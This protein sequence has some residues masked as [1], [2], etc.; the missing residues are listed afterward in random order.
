MFL[1][2]L[3]G[4]TFTGTPCT[5]TPFPS[6][7]SETSH[8]GLLPLNA[9]VKAR[10]PTTKSI[11]SHLTALTPSQPYYIY[12]R[13]TRTCTASRVPINA[14]AYAHTKNGASSGSPH[15]AL[16][17]LV[18]FCF[19]S[20][21]QCTHR[22]HCTR[23]C[24]CPQLSLLCTL[25]ESN[26]PCKNASASSHSLGPLGRSLPPYQFLADIFLSQQRTPM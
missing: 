15:N 26:D 10:N 6:S 1:L 18:V 20:C 3:A 23:Q 7:I 5:H 12:T 2:S 4:E 9:M 8:S 19:R 25:W 21:K 13:H 17:S 14:K 16:H 22:C 11:A 24:L